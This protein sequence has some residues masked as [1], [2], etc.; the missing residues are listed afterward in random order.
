MNTNSMIS[1][2]PYLS[3]VA[4]SRNDDH[5]GNLLKRMQLFVDS[6]YT[7]CN[8]YQLKTE[9]I[10]VEWN[11]LSDRQGLKE[12]LIWPQDREYIVTRIITVLPEIHNQF[13]YADKLP[14]FQMIGKN[15]GISRA[16]G[17]FILATN[18][19]ILFSDELMRY[20]S[21]KL[22]IDGC[23]YRVD[24]IDVDTC[25]MSEY[26]KDSL[27]SCCRKHMLRLNKKYGTYRYR[28]KW[29]SLS[30][31]LKH[32]KDRVSRLKAEKDYG[33]PLT[34][35]NACGDFALMAKSDWMKLGGYPE[36]EMYSFHIDS[37][38]LVA[39][40]YSGISE[41]DLTSPYEIYHIEH[42]AGSGW[43]PGKGEQQLFERLN[44]SGVPYLV[45]NDLLRYSRE[46]R[47]S[48]DPEQTFIG[49]NKPSWGLMN[50][51]LPE[52]VIQ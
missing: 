28:N 17:D 27:L 43:T 1:A 26:T 20:L 12:A 18:I 14:V 44:K 48:H 40:H 42:S 9:L 3:I 46:L 49:K 13:K 11:P 50:Q 39:G 33:Y 2:E 15:V 5:G 25:V 8:R 22:L 4:V 6:L 19:D 16:K 21:K 30:V 45:W 52:T 41:I 37:I 35:S 38:I 31:L 24:R 29:D 10:I 34:H 51:E 36:L 32:H 47:D 7:Q 23:H